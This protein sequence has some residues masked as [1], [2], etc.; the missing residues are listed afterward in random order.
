MAISAK[1][2]YTGNFKV[3]AYSRCADIR[4]YVEIGDTY[5]KIYRKILQNTDTCTRKHTE[6]PEYTRKY[7][8]NPENMG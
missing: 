8:Q 1:A 5:N 3:E 2:S 4:K 6:K 7:K